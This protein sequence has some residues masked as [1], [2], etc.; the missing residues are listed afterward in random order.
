MR[1]MRIYTIQ[2]LRDAALARRSVTCR[3]GRGF[4][5]PKPAAFVINLQGHILARMLD[6][7]IYLYEKTKGKRNE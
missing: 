5:K 1:G 3:S 6:A 7:G 4:A 2:G